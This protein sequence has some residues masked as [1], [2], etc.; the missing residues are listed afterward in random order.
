MQSGR[1]AAFVLGIAV[2]ATSPA[3][4]SAHIDLLEPEPRAHGTAARGDTDVDVNSNLKNAPCGQ[5]TT[6]RTDRVTTYAPGQRITVRVREE[7][8]HVSYLRVRL[9]LD[10]A[11]FPLRTEA[12]AAPETQE[13][14]MAAEFA[15]GAEGLLAVVREDNDTPGFVHELEV[16]LPNETCIAC[17]L[18]IAQFMYDDPAAP[19]YFQCADLVI[20][21]AGRAGD[22]GRPPEGGGTNGAS[23]NGADNAG[24]GDLDPG[25]PIDA[26]A[27]GSGTSSENPT[28]GASEMSENG[29]ADG[30]PA[31]DRVPPGGLQAPGGPVAASPSGNTAEGCTFSPETSSATRLMRSLFGLA[32][33]ALGVASA[34]R[35]RR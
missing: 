2:V 34:R 30:V 35:R 23:A 14:A 19:H 26:E 29:T 15:L 22:A 12:P 31:A 27:V 16:T 5:I 9:D 6:E 25:V 24:P 21:D 20:A 32:L 3:T 17:T 10:G 7:N 1:R 13:V 11:D 33:A 4:A 18:Q 28:A 8:A